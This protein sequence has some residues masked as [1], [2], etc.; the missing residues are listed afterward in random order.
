MDK[1]LIRLGMLKPEA[2]H[3]QRVCNWFLVWAGALF[4][5]GLVLVIIGDIAST[6]ILWK[7]AIF[8]FVG[9]IVF[10]WGAG[11]QEQDEQERRRKMLDQS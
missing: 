5:G 9:S 1:L 10:H 6:A 7:G 11:T 4:A 8:I 3:V 2:T